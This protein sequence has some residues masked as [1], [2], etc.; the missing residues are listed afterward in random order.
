MNISLSHWV[1]G[2]K[3]FSKRHS[4]VMTRRNQFN[5]LLC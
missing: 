4:V 5:Q 1:I 3:V 2:K